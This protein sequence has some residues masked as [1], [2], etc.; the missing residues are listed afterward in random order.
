MTGPCQVEVQL[1]QA[2]Q[3]RK[4]PTKAF[5]C[6]K[7]VHISHASLLPH[8]HQGDESLQMLPLASCPH[9]T[10]GWVHLDLR[11]QLRKHTH[12]HIHTDTTSIIQT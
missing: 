7:L 11:C 8:F 4:A 12:K 6:T 2:A 10:L 5:L 9:S 1:G 3:G